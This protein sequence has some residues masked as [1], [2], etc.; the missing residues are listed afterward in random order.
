MECD[1]ADEKLGIGTAGKRH[2]GKETVQA[3][4]TYAFELFNKGMMVPSDLEEKYLEE[5]VKS[6]EIKEEQ[7]YRDPETKKIKWVYQ[8]LREVIIT[9]RINH[10]ATVKILDALKNTFPQINNFSK[11]QFTNDSG[12][13]KFKY[14]IHFA[15]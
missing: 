5:L 6:G 8:S 14:K 3:I 9:T 7:C 11:E 2:I 13:E 1:Y 10:V 4:I 12:I 15:K